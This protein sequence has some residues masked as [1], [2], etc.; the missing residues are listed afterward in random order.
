M[1]FINKLYIVFIICIGYLL[2]AGNNKEIVIPDESLRFRIIPNSNNIEDQSIKM[3]VKDNLQKILPNIIG[4]SSNILE[5]EENINSNI[6]LIKDNIKL[7]AEI[8]HFLRNKMYDLGFTEVQTPILTA[9]WPE[10]YYESLVI[11]LGEAKGDNWWCVLFP[12]LCLVE[13]EESSEV[14]YKLYIKEIFLFSSQ[15]FFKFF[16]FFS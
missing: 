4:N 10:G 5:I 8:L 7:R 14:E 6:D 16:I 13:A 2:Y 9:S 15:H 1:I 3:K 12:P 11:S